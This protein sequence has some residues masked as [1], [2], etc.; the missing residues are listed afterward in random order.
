MCIYGSENAS[1]VGRAWYR[2]CSYRHQ[3]RHALADWTTDQNIV[4]CPAAHGTNYAVVVVCVGGGGALGT[5][6]ARSMGPEVI[7]LGLYERPDGAVGSAESPTRSENG[8]LYIF[9]WHCDPTGQR[10]NWVERDGYEWSL[11]KLEPCIFNIRI[12]IHFVLQSGNPCR[13]G[14]CESHSFRGRRYRTHDLPNYLL[15]RSAKFKIN[16]IVLFVN[17]RNWIN[18]RTWRH[19]WRHRAGQSKNVFNR[20]DLRRLTSKT[21]SLSTSKANDWYGQCLRHL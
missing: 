17:I 8:S 16:L 7:C 11:M 19:W 2:P 3:R 20:T 13:L 9:Y 1:P 18:N 12:R 4:T 10:W 15:S 5:A 21:S 6:G 14:C